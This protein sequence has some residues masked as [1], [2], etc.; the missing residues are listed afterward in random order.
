MARTTQDKADIPTPSE[1]GGSWS[2]RR[3]L[4]GAGKLA[5]AGALTA[6][7][8]AFRISPAEAACAAP[9]GFPSGIALYQQAYVNWARDIA[10]D[11]MWTCAPATPAEVVAVCNWART[12]GF[13]VRPLGAM[14]NWSPLTVPQGASCPSVILVD[15]KSHL[16]AVSVNTATT[17]KTVTAQT[18]VLMENLLAT[19]ESYTLGVNACPAPGDLTLGGALAIDGHG[20]GVPKTGETLVSGNTYGSLSNLIRA[21]TAVVWDAASNQYALRSFQRTDPGCAA[22]LTHVGRAFV[23]E[24]TLQVGTN[25]RLRCQSWFDKTAAE[26]FAPAGSSGN[27]VQS[28]LNSAGRFEAI[29]FPFTPKPWIKVWS[30]APSKPWFSREVT[31]PYNYSFSDGIAQS[32]VDAQAQAV[33]ND[34]SSTPDFGLNQ[35]NVVAAGLVLTNTWDL[36]G[37]SKN[38]LLYIRPTT[39]RVTANGYA[40]I[41]SRA[42]VQR[43][44]NEFYTMYSAKLAAYQ[45][46]GKF[47]MNGPVEIRITG[48]DRASDLVGLSAPTPQ[49]SALR[50]RPDHPEWDTAVWFDI[51]TIPGTQ[52]ANEFYR[53]VEQWMYANYASYAAVRVEW[54]KGWG[55]STT[56]AWSDATVLGTTVPNSLRAGQ[57]AGD[58][59]DSARATLN[60]LDPSRL[61]ASPLLD[62]VLP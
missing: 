30:V 37:W 22:L 52:Y 10:V 16:T 11:P 61:F 38:T 3:F 14:H 60:A 58:D 46:A 42:N 32:I 35:Y 50:P 17:P 27:T 51:L 26:L 55:Y 40:V 36:W 13:K 54:S 25:Q 18:G 15:T 28:Y 44:I 4:D 53:E 59:F 12:A 8:P 47:P 31:S 24:V 1:T 48:L 57:T 21:L 19:L 34:P 9:A 29:W 62:T 39:L 49:L 2:R 43:A 23:V 5:A 7:L 33:L 56:A 45:A 6:W 41:L 20:T